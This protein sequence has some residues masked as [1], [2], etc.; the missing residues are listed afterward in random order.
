[1]ILYYFSENLQFPNFVYGHA[2]YVHLHVLVNST[3]L[4]STYNLFVF[5]HSRYTDDY[6]LDVTKPDTLLEAP[7]IL[8]APIKLL[9]HGYT[10]YKDYSP[11][12]ELRPGIP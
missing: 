5:I 7:F 4:N 11:N 12:T 6:V 10:G 9:I 3:K 2:V 8:H 1:M